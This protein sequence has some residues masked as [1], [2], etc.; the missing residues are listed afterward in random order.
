[1]MTSGSVSPQRVMRRGVAKRVHD[2]WPL[3]GMRGAGRGD[4]RVGPSLVPV[5]RL[6]KPDRPVD[7]VRDI[8]TAGV[9]GCHTGTDRFPQ[10]TGTHVLQRSNG[11]ALRG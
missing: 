2:V 3:A 4:G 1:M 5:Q 9:R 7:P 6:G 10:L 11:G 8:G